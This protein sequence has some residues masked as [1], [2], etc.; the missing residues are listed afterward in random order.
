MVSFNVEQKHRF[1]F[2][3]P[4]AIFGLFHFNNP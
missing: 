2:H 3:F 4:S 1:V